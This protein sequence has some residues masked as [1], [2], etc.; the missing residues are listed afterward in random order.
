MTEKRSRYRAFERFMTI[1]LFIALGMFLLFL[2]SAG[3]GWAVIKITAAILI[4]LLCAYGLWLLYRAR[5]LLTARSFYL[6]CAF[7][8]LVL[9]TAVSLLCNFPR[10]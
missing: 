4:L 7:G 2:M 9:L 1:L 10:P 3:L 6:T 8:C 5:E